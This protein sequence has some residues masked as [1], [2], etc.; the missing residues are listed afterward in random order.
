M[1]SKRSAK[2]IAIDGKYGNAGERGECSGIQCE[3]C[4]IRGA[5][6][7]RG[8]VERP[9]RKNIMNHTLSKS[10]KTQG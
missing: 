3:Y 6:E 9:K 2:M 10:D 1:E 5:D 4:R 8:R 7:M